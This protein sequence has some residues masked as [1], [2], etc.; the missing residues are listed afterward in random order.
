MNVYDCIFYGSVVR[1]LNML[2]SN[3]EYIRMLIIDLLC[4]VRVS[5]INIVNFISWIV[6]KEE[7]TC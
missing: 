6:N 1:L 7:S 4:Q 3:Y 5:N 2:A